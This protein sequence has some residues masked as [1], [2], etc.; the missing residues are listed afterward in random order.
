MRWTELGVEWSVLEAHDLS[1]LFLDLGMLS[2]AE[3]AGC[4]LQ[5]RSVFN[6]VAREAP[7]VVLLARD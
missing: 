7:Q 2:F 6:P 1:A 3:V 5:Y 4:I